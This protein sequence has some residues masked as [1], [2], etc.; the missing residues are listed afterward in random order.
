MKSLQVVQISDS[1]PVS[2]IVSL[3]DSGIYRL[4]GQD[5]RFVEQVLFNDI[6]AESFA[7]ETRTTILATLPFPRSDLQDILVLSSRSTMTERS[8]VRP[9]LRGGSVE[10]LTRLVQ[11]FTKML[12]QT[13]GSDIFA[14]DAGGGLYDLV[15]QVVSSTAAS[16]LVARHNLSV[17]RTAEQIQALQARSD[18]YVP[19]A[20]RLLGAEVLTVDFDR[21]TSTLRSRVRLRSAAGEALLNLATD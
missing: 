15:G 12:L 11:R 2:R 9:S 1:I 19:A 20:E 16:D 7:I 13:P 21:N 5:F 10:G 3:G 6:D 18:R 17:S 8:L 14:P 4:Y